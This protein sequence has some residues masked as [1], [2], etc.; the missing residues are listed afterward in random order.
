MGSLRCRRI[1]E[2]LP[3]WVNGTLAGEE[4]AEVERHLRRCRRC[5]A[6]VEELRELKIGLGEALGGLKPSAGLLEGALDLIEAE[7]RL[8]EEVV[9]LFSLTRR[10]EQEP[11]KQ[12]SFGLFVLGFSL[13][14]AYERGGLPFEAE[15]SALGL[16]LAK[17]K[18]R[19]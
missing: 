12:L 16:P 7:A 18:G 3:W 11:L 19:L 10:E 6:E 4:R 17:I 15:L 13:G 1:R 8:E 2:L 5:R 9:K 14:M